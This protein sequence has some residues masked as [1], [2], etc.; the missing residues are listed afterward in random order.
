MITT[1]KLRGLVLGEFKGVLEFPL[2]ILARVGMGRKINEHLCT[3][4]LLSI[5]DEIIS[6]EGVHV[7]N[8]CV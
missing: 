7:H 1:R 3:K 8:D 2:I 4:F 6:C 5:I